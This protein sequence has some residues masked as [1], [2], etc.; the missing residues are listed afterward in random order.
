MFIQCV[1]QE[2][3]YMSLLPKFKKII[4]FDGVDNIGKLPSYNHL[5][6]PLGRVFSRVYTL[7]RISLM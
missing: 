4:I 6:F 1:K 5:M 7:I 2:G 3:T